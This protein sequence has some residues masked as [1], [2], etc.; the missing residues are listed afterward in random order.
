MAASTPARQVAFGSPYPVASVPIEDRDQPP[1]DAAAY[2]QPRDGAWIDLAPY[3]VG[4]YHPGRG[5][6]VRLLWILVSCVFFEGGWFVLG[7]VKPWLLRLFGATIGRGVVLKPN[8]RIKYP[9]R[10]SI[11]DHVWVGQGTWIDNIVGVEIGSHVCIS[12]GVYFCTGSHDHRRRTFDL[13]PGEIRVGSGA[14]VAAQATLLP[15]VTVGRNALVAVCSVVTK[16]VPPGVIV[17]G[18]PARVLRDREPPE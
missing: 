10:L 14:W 9:W 11:G 8:L 4:D 5:A 17:A 12:Q 1:T 2:V 16:D 18:N 15:G 6:L 3:T 13:T 7:S